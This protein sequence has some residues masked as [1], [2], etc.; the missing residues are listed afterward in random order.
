MSDSLNKTPVSEDILISLANPEVINKLSESNQKVIIENVI[1]NKNWDGVFLGMLFVNKK[2]NASMN[3][4]FVICLLLAV[5]G[6]ISMWC[7]HER[8]DVIIPAIMTAVGYMF[9]VG[10][11]SN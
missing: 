3:I 11:K 9:G 6:S 5:I 4:A 8:W 10:V 1:N 2:Q 7:G